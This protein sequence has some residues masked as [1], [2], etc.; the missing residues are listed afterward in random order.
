MVFNPWDN[1]R[2]DVLLIFDY[3]PNVNIIFNLFEFDPC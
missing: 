2:Y 1:N 3:S